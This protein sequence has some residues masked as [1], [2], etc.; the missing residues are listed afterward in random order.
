[1]RELRNVIER[2]VVLAP[3]SKLTVRDLPPNIQS[4]VPGQ[5]AADNKA[6]TSLAEAERR[7]IVATLRAQK[8]NRTLAARQLG[9]SRRTLHR[10]LHE[11]GLMQ[12][13]G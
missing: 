5:A 7:M 8:G 6:A 2:M 9:I 13:K 12:P 1:M 11:F 4:I 3:G 10:K